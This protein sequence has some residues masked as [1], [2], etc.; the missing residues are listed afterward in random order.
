MDRVTEAAVRADL[1]SARFRAGC[2]RGSWRLVSADRQVLLIAVMT[3]PGRQRRSEYAFR[4]DVTDFPTQ[5]PE[6]KIWDPAQGV[7]LPLAE[8]PTGTPHIA[9]AFKDGWPGTGAPSVYRPWERSGVTHNNWRATHPY[10]IWH[11]GRDLAFV[12]EDLYALINSSVPQ[13]AAA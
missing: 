12:L 6:V 9:D 1:V 3:I 2:A 7:S 10:L 13:A 8:R 5:A 4:F 11:A